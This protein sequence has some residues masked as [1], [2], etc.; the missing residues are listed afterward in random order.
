MRPMKS[1]RSLRLH[2]DPGSSRC[3]NNYVTRSQCSR[4]PKLRT[5]LM[6][7]NSCF[8]G[9]PIYFISCA[10]IFY[11]LRSLFLPQNYLFYFCAP[12]FYFLRS[13]FLFSHASHA[14]I[15]GWSSF[16]FLRFRSVLSFCLCFSVF[17]LGFWF[18]SWS[19]LCFG[20]GARGKESKF[21]L[22]GLIIL[23]IPNPQ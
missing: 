17:V 6:L 18:L 7:H 15:V 3:T 10:L 5:T 19:F 22:H 9:I 11:F 4:V 23:G 8:F 1:W 21:R 16:G 14:H 20:S 13:L 12:C 2:H